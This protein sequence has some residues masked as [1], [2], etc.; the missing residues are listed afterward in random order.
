VGGEEDRF[1]SASLLINSLCDENGEP[2]FAAGEGE[3]AMTVDG[4]S[5][6]I[7]LDAILA[8]NGLATANT[9]EASAAE[10]N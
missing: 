8:L 5:L 1:S 3:Q 7:I 6:K 10:K 4:V 2:L 9:G